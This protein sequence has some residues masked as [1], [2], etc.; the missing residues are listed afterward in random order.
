MKR[1][2]SYAA[3]IAFLLIMLYFGGFFLLGKLAPRYP[4]VNR[5]YSSFYYSLRT[6]AERDYLN[7]IKTY[8]GELYYSMDSDGGLAK[9]PRVEGAVGF[10]VPDTLRDEIYDLEAGTML[11]V[12]IG[13]TLDEESIGIY[14]YELRAF[15]VLPE[16]TN[17][18]SDEPNATGDAGQ[19]SN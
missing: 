7:K 14:Y 16:S 6:F 18:K 19:K 12:D 15:R 2:A 5:F 10:Q 11:E 13:M 9:Y 8:R 17:P 4:G 3:A 1:I